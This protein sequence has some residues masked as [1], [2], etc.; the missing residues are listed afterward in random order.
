MKVYALVAVL[1]LLGLI[2]GYY[3]Y[4]TY[5]QTQSNIFLSLIDPANVPHGTQSL[6]ITYSS[7]MVHTI[8]GNTSGWTSV[9]GSGTLNLL[10]LL[11]VS[12]VLG[13]LYL[14]NGSRVNIVRFNVTSANIEINNTVYPVAL[15]NNQVTANVQNHN[16][17]NGTTDLITELS[18]TVI[19]IFTANSTLFVL[20]PSA[21]A[22]LV[23]NKALRGS[24]RGSQREL[25]NKEQNALNLNGVNIS[26]L[27]PVLSTSGN[28]TQ[29]SINVKDD[30]NQ[31]VTLK[32]LLIFGNQ[33][34]STDSIS[35]GSRGNISR[36]AGR[37]S[38]ASIDNNSE[39]HT[40]RETEN[41]GLSQVQFRTI[42]FL[43][44]Q[45]GSLLLPSL[46]GDL[47]GE[48]YTLA[49]GQTLTLTFDSK[50]LLG[51]NNVLVRLINNSQYR[52]VVQGED[53][54]RASVNVTAS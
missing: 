23:G 53:G 10:S 13:S 47:E 2:A 21:R 11:N 31:S 28:V 41:Q 35:I 37:N 17:I 14:P 48:G 4:I 43:I 8:S 36:D 49:A 50:I 45:N 9:S 29:I 44:S 42:N 24:A 22:V 20:I 39:N 40:E 26:L 1:V 32:N 46:G 3:L 6:N 15:Y 34:V 52:L 54:A 16:M 25:D 7:L 30:S 33:T 12:S 19:P 51:E 5:A 27:N 38:S 18:P